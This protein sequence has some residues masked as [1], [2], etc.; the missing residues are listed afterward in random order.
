MK[1]T[2]KKLKGYTFLCGCLIQMQMPMFAIKHLGFAPGVTV[3]IDTQRL[4][5]MR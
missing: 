3:N 1:I 4:D 2:L 5:I